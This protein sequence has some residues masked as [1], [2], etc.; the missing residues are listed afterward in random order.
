MKKFEEPIIDVQKFAVEDVITSSDVIP[1]DGS[2]G[3]SGD[4]EIVP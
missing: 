2:A 3:S 1:G 4:I